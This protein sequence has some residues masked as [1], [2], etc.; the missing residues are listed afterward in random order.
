M[1]TQVEYLSQ[2]ETSRAERHNR[3]V[4]VEKATWEQRDHEYAPILPY[5]GCAS[6]HIVGN[7]RRAYA[8]N[9]LH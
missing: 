1:Q 9:C 8:A 6:R 5:A 3:A 7:R 4:L 2:I